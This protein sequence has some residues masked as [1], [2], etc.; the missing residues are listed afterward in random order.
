[1]QHKRNSDRSAT[2]TVAIG[3]IISIGTSILLSGAAALLVINGR[4]KEEHIQYFAYAIQC[5]A[6]I[7]GAYVT[8]KLMKQKPAVVC[9]I[10]SGMYMLL[11]LAVNILLIDS[12][13][14]NLLIT[15]VAVALG[16]AC[17]CALCIPRRD[18]RKYRKVLNR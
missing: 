6:A 16:W 1:M 12:G 9:G 2:A 7:I 5:I 17:S 14:S 11:L 13:I 10:V 3:V 18:K 4:M 15:L 8:G